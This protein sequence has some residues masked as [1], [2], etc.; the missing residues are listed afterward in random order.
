M[1]L[2]H[3]RSLGRYFSNGFRIAADQQQFRLVDQASRRVFQHPI[4]DVDPTVTLLGNEQAWCS[5]IAK[6]PIR[7]HPILVA[8]P[9][10][11]AHLVEPEVLCVLKK[12]D[13][14]FLI[15]GQRTVGRA[16]TV[17][18]PPGL[19]GRSLDQPVPVGIV[20]HRQVLEFRDRR[21][22]ASGNIEQL[23]ILDIA[24]TVVVLPVESFRR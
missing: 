24:L 17:L 21:E 8:L 19:P 13:K 23:Q 20:E 14:R 12:R 2:A 4:V 11:V 6:A 1:K 16:V 3:R 10:P 22:H 7:C 15:E 9:F 5:A 18:G